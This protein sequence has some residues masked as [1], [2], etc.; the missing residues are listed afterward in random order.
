MEQLR[1]LFN[2]KNAL[3]MPMSGTGSAGMETAF[4]KCTEPGDVV[5]VGV[6]GVF[7]QRMVSPALRRRGYRRSPMG[8]MIDPGRL[9][10]LS[11]TRRSRRAI[12][13]AE[14]SPGFASP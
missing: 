12:V 5:V 4:W 8:E 10:R 13:H 7:G 1:I 6:K 2:T 3:T 11:N 14:T 9:K